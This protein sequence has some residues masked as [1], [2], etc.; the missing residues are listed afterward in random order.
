[1]RLADLVVRRRD[2]GIDVETRDGAER[3]DALE[4]FDSF[5][6]NWCFREFSLHP[7]SP[8]A[9]RISVGDLIMQRQS[10]RMPSGELAFAFVKSE[11][12]RFLRARDFAR[13]RSLPRQLFV[14][15]AGEV[16]P[17]YVDFQSPLSVDLFCRFVRRAHEAEANGLVR[18]SEMLPTLEQAWLKD[19]NGDR[20]TSEL[21]IVAVDPEP[22]RPQRSHPAVASARLQTRTG[23]G[24]ATGKRASARDRPSVEGIGNRIL[25]I[26]GAPRH[27][28]SCG[29]QGLNLA[30]CRFLATQF[31]AKV[32]L[33]VANTRDPEWRYAK[34]AANLAPMG[35]VRVRDFDQCVIIGAD[36]FDGSFGELAVQSMIEKVQMFDSV[37]KPVRLISLSVGERIAPSVLELWKLLPRH[38]PICVRDP[39]SYDRIR[40]LLPDH[41]ILSTADVAFLC[42]VWQ[43]ATYLERRILQFTQN[44][45]VV[46]INGSLREDRALADLLAMTERLIE[47]SDAQFLFLSHDNRLKAGDTKFIDFV[48][49]RFGD[50]PRFMYLR[51]ASYPVV[52][53]VVRQIRL[54]ITMRMHLA[55]AA[56]DAGCPALFFEYHGKGRGL[57]A[58]FDLPQLCGESLSPNLAEQYWNVNHNESVRRQI[59]ARLEKVRDLARLNFAELSVAARA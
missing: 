46:C 51:K 12:E 36:V 44:G 19:C 59:S 21:R 9:P 57:Y 45:N 10:W 22:W 35:P 26:P 28:G 38:V 49:R 20:Y 32:S 16:K 56:L 13:A 39:V 24:R 8:Y 25:V 29:D 6:V 47:N 34:E 27:P 23:V 30:T 7:V 48:K 52:K 42:E 31:G 15:V 43:P 14:R 50:G 4:V 54:T 58:L 17:I 1:L 5:L 55:I 40:S 41:K 18:M 53:W 33:L 37:G 3:F 2:G 11:D